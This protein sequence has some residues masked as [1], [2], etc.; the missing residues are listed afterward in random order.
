MHCNSA[1]ANLWN[2]AFISDRYLCYTFLVKY[3]ICRSPSLPLALLL[4]LL[5]PLR[6]PCPVLE[7][8]RP[9]QVHQDDHS[10][11]P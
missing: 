4:H 3:Q 8:A 6:P 7:R 11:F 2:E 5:F 1:P 10:N 9:P